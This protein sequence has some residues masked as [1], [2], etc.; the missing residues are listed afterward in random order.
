MKK[1]VIILSVIVLGFFIYA[2]SISKNSWSDIGSDAIYVEY[3]RDTLDSN[4]LDSALRT[5]N[6]HPDIS[7]WSTMKYYSPYK[8][9][10][11][12]FIYTKND[13]TFIINKINDDDYIFFVRHLSNK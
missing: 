11:H 7:E 13:T 12:Q 1:I 6:V 4:Q 3:C 9:E 10:M 5:H 2:C 8:E